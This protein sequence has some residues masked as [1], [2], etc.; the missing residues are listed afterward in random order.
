[1]KYLEADFGYI[2]SCCP[3]CGCNPCR[4]PR[5]SMSGLGAVM[6]TLD[7]VNSQTKVI[8]Q[9]VLQGKYTLADLKLYMGKAQAGDWN[10]WLHNVEGHVSLYS[11]QSGVRLLPIVK[12]MEANG[13]PIGWNGG[14]S[15]SDLLAKHNKDNPNIE[16]DWNTAINWLE[17]R[18]AAIAEKEKEQREAE[19][20]ALSLQKQIQELKAQNE[21]AQAEVNQARLQSQKIKDE[22]QQAILKAELK[23]KEAEAKRLALIQK[24][25]RE[26]IE[27]KEKRAKLVKRGG[28]VAALATGAY[29]FLGEV[30]F[31]PKPS[32]LTGDA[33]SAYVQSKS[34]GNFL[35]D[36][37]WELRPGEN[38]VWNS[39]RRD[40]QD[41]ALQKLGLQYQGYRNNYGNYNPDKR[42]KPLAQA[43]RNYIS[44]LNAYSKYAKYQAEQDS[45]EQLA[46]QKQLQELKMQNELAQ[47]EVA[48]AS[49]KSQQIKD[50]LQQ[51]I[52]KAQLEREKA[53]AL[54]KKLQVEKQQMQAQMELEK[55]QAEEKRKKLLKRG[56]LVAAAATGA[57]FL[58]GD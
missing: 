39:T 57:F 42:G 45:K 23:A 35:Y 2:G 33:Y 54:E 43:V 37:A 56:G 24:T 19:L 26:K 36:L 13:Q 48:A 51:A 32:A 12:H 30:P 4:C 44:E 20:Q 8:I 34:D 1:M 9:G 41:Y 38:F 31:A 50:E 18:N 21:M 22:L 55:Q 15:Y 47:A 17:R 40:R 28:L 16:N 53:L 25:E 5:V 29:V 10:W 3:N 52:L 6:P 58:L 11:P 49:R 27:S 46:L 7:E 14:R